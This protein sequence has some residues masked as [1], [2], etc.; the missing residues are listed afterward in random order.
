MSF[1]QSPSGLFSIIDNA[2]KIRIVKK[3]MN[4]ENTIDVEQIVCY[5]EQTRVIGNSAT[6]R[7]PGW[8]LPDDLKNFVMET[9]GNIVIMGSK[10]YKSLPKSFR[11][12][13]DRINII[14]SR[15][16]QFTPEPFVKNVT[17][18][19]NSIETALEL[20]ESLLV[21]DQKI[22]VIGGGEIYQQVL[23]HPRA[24]VV[25]IVASEVQGAFEGNVFFPVIPPEK[26]HVG[27][28]K[29]FPLTEFP[30]NSH[31]FK[32]VEYLLN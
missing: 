22:F 1:N 11:P 3:K 25:R 27:E 2:S 21:G 12:L 15:N 32:I 17:Y 23:S 20:A 6:N 24:R 7:M 14:V 13:S 26:Y 9:I 10:T 19:A 28:V 29:L 4:M 31:Y 16:P 5:G 18:V 8:K 30:Q